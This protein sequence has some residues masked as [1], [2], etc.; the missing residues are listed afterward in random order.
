MSLF[1]IP[2]RN[3]LAISD[4][5]SKAKDDYTYKPKIKLKSGSL[6]G[7]LEA[8]RNNVLNSLGDEKDKFI[9]ISDNDSFIDYCTKA[10][11]C[12]YVALDTETTGLDNMLADLVGV[13]IQGD[14]MKPAYVSVGHTSVVTEENF[15]NQVS[16]KCIAEGLNMLIKNDTK[17]LMHNA[18]YDIVELVNQCNIRV[19]VYFDTLIASNCL[20]ENEP[21]SLKYLYDKYVM[22]GASGVHKFA[23]LFAG[24]P[25]NYI[26]SDIAGIYGAHDAT[27][28][29]DL[30]K[31]L[32]PYLTEGTEENRAC[33]LEKLVNEFWNIEMKMIDV[34]VDMKLNGM[35]FDFAR[36]NQLRNKYVELKEQALV[37]FNN[38]VNAYKPKIDSYNAN[39]NGYIQVPVNYNSPSQ[40][41]AL[42]YDIAKVPEG[43]YKK[44]PRGTGKDVIDIILHDDRFKNKPVFDIVKYL[45]DVKMY[46][47]A[48]SS[49]IDK[50]TKDAKIHNG[51]IH[52]NINLAATRTG[53]L[54]SSEPNMQQVPSKLGDIRNMFIGG[55]GKVIVGC[56][57]SKQEPCILASSCK[58]PK[59]IKVFADGLDIYSMIASMAFD[60]T[61]EDCLEHYED[62]TTNHDGKDR[63]SAAKKIVLG[64]MYSR[65]IASVAEQI[66]KS[67]EDAQ[68]LFDNLYLKYDKMAEWMRGVVN[69]AYKLGYVET[70]YG[71]RRRLPELKLP[72]YSFEF[73]I[74]SYGHRGEE[75]YRGVYTNKLNSCRRRED[76]LPI[77]A[78][79]KKHGIII[80]DNES[81]IKKAEREIVNFCIQGGASSV[82]KRAMLNIANNA[83]L[84]ELGAYLI[85]SIHDENLVVCNKE[86]AYEV[87]KIVEKCSIDAG[88]GLPVP[89]ACDL[90][91]SDAWY[92]SEYTF[93]DNH[94]LVLLDN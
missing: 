52:C 70:I 20:N 1:N 82:S 35:V 44:S 6:M 83:R 33:K 73:K 21:H 67:K 18:Y 2:K 5:V 78:E 27:M 54:A 60:C 51:K 53:R 69:N 42:L 13:C 57:F 81:C 79:A 17:F 48:I 92:G 30:S 45:S 43:I 38:A 63:R 3:S 88:E 47:K 90:A 19:P 50:L 36:A 56:D 74:D 89:L 93:N 39:G 84:K 68:K 59:L 15:V 23:D 72:K 7:K 55:E 91:I 11:L 61:Y 49:F 46:D 24:I 76:R 8:I 86:D 31:V 26:P 75:Y 14:G 37:E 87:S 32:L 94:E 58:D 34:V 9:L 41:S 85:L 25:I 12:K 71:R 80:T 4:V 65:G 16:K 66:H 22:N 77:I 40:I 28:T 62:G 29:L 64:L 10:K